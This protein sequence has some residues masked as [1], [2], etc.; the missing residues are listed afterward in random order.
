[1]MK[2]YPV[3]LLEVVM[4]LLIEGILKSLSEMKIMQELT[5]LVCGQ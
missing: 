2:V 1:M 3:I 4:H 5:K